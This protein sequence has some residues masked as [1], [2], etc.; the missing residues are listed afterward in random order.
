MAL[1][2][3]PAYTNYPII[4]KPSEIEG[5]E[6]N[7]NSK[8]R[9]HAKRT[10]ARHD[11][12]GC[13]FLRVHALELSGHLCNCVTCCIGDE[14]WKWY[15]WQEI[16]VFFLR[17]YFIVEYSD[18]FKISMWESCK[19]K[20]SN[21]KWFKPRRLLWD[22]IILLHMLLLTSSLS[23]LFSIKIKWI[24]SIMQIWQTLKLTHL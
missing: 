20:S 21:N 8:H 14:P 5:V 7:C 15:I 11:I 2:T 9:R 17:D 24:V 23:L 19:I 10:S 6:L 22:H 16:N 4:Q 12:C 3:T 1:S 13:L 18:Y